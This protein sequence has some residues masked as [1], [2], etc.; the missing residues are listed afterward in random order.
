MGWALLALLLVRIG[1]S[2]EEQQ[3]AHQQDLD[4]C[5][6]ALEAERSTHSATRAEHA[7]LLDAHQSKCVELGSLKEEVAHSN[8]MR[9][10]RHADDLK[11]A[12]DLHKAEVDHVVDE[13]IKEARELQEEFKMAKVMMADQMQ[14]L[15]VRVATHCR[16]LIFGFKLLGGILFYG[17]N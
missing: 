5:D 11:H 6:N 7:T 15:E 12:A 8:K 13:N 10:L 16:A 17:W 4:K 2:M 9:E 3:A 1:Q 14:L